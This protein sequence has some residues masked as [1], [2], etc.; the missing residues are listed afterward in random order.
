MMRVISRIY[1]R[2]D[3]RSKYTK[4]DRAKMYTYVPKNNKRGKVKRINPAQHVWEMEHGIGSY[5]TYV[6]GSKF[7]DADVLKSMASTDPLILIMGA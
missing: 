3:V 5:C 6:D 4:G 2:D 7:S 1:T